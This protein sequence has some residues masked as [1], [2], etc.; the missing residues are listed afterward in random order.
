MLCVGIN[1]AWQ[2]LDEYYSKT[3]QSPVYLAAV[4]LLPGLEW[5]WLGKAWR[6]SPDWINRARV[7]VKKLWLEYAEIT[8]N[9]EDSESLK[10]E[11]NACW[12]DE[13]LSSD[14]S[15]LENDTSTE[16]EYR[17]R[18]FWSTKRQKQ[19]YPRLLRMVRN[20]FTVP[21]MSDEPERIFLCAGEITTTHRGRLSARTIRKAQCIKGWIKTGI[22]TKF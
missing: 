4:A 13:D 22:I 6:G 21:A 7:E 20:L 16:N 5:K 15:D 1:L 3:D 10:V 2:K 12:M 9:T 19:A 11:D 18:E 17:P 14:F 8:V